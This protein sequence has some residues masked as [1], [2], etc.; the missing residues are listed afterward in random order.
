MN[1]VQRNMAPD[2]DQDFSVPFPDDILNSTRS[3]R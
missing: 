2:H 1:A 3:C